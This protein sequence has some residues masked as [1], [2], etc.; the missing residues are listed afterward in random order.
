MGP[1]VDWLSRINRRQP[2]AIAKSQITSC[3]L[4]ISNKFQV[5]IFESQ[6]KTKNQ[7]LFVLISSMGVFGM[8]LAQDLVWN[9]EFDCW[10]LF[11]IWFLSFGSW[12]LSYIWVSTCRFR[13]CLQVASVK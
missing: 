7:Q 9:F 8:P 6:N 5:S 11:V 1:P 4:Q 3:K 13:R 2:I 12:L 10:D